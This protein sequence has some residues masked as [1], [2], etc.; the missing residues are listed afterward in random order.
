LSK[1]QCRLDS[2]SWRDCKSP[3]AF[4][5]LA[6]GSHTF[7][8]R[9][10]SD[11]GTD[12]SPAK[13]TWRIA[14]VPG[15]S[16][17]AAV[18]AGG[19]HTCTLTSGGAVKCWGFNSD[20][21]VGDGTKIDRTTPVPVS[22]L[23]SG[24]IALSAGVFHTCALTGGGSAKC[25]GA[26]FNGQLGDGT[27]TGSSTPVSVSGLSSGVIALS[28]GSFHTCALTS[29]GA[30]KCWGFN[31]D[32]QLGDGTQTDSATPV[33]VSGLSSGVTALSAGGDH[34][35]ALTSGGAVKC[36]GIN[37]NGQLGDGTQ[38][39]S[40]TPVSVSGLS[41]GVIALSAGNAHT[42]ALTSGGAVKCWGL[43]AE[44]QLGDGTQVDRSAPVSVSGLSSGVTALTA[45]GIHSCAVG[46]GGAAECWGSN[47][48]G[49]LGDGTTIE[50][51][52]PVSV[53]G[54]SSGV[55]AL[56]AGAHHTCA[57]TSGGAVKCWGLNAEGQLGD[58]TTTDR[59]TPVSVV[60][61]GG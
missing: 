2:G 22:G 39:D 44:G 51:D 16:A 25:W 46:S 28:A 35:C 10:R 57:L 30:V 21:Q 38:T 59:L 40:P 60:G 27:T 1:F 53:S 8:V 47:A 32:G 55:I 33:P 34:T 4:S 15:V 7:S 52:T 20:G 18:G 6:K 58:G 14:Q 11:I 5:R 24:V 26:D 49:Q 41:S 3:R 13:R 17:A 29:G 61:F 37:A 31:A 56:S 19:F 9:A 36:W 43:N 50:R 23:S 48:Q 54:L 42:C 12:A 45:D